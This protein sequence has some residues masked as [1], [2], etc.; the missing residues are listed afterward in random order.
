[1]IKTVRKARYKSSQK[2]PLIRPEERKLQEDLEEGCDVKNSPS[3]GD[4]LRS[5]METERWRC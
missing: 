5:D 1:M 3:T 4:S 2:G